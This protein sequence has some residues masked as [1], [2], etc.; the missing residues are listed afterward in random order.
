MI[1]RRTV[2][3]QSAPPTKRA[4]LDIF[5]QEHEQILNAIRDRAVTQ[6][7][8]AMQRH[9]LNSRGRYEKLAA[10]VGIK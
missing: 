6:A 10:E 9:L 3:G 7:R 4:H 1:P 8:A 2:W 5:Q